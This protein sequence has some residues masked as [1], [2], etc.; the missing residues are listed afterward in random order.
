MII[1]SIYVSY[2]ID[3]NDFEGEYFVDNSEV[4]LSK[5][6]LKKILH[7]PL[8]PYVASMNGIMTH[9]VQGLVLAAIFFVISIQQT[10]NIMLICNLIICF[11]IVVAMWHNSITI[12]QYH[13]MRTN[14]FDTIFPIIT[15][16]FQTILALAIS[17]PIY[18]F[19]AL[20]TVIF[21]FIELMY[22]DH[23]REDK[24]PQAKEIFKQHFKDLGPQFGIDV[25]D[26]FMNFL[27][28]GIKKVFMGIVI[29]SILTLFNYLFPI[30]LDW[31]TYISTVIILILLIASSYED[32][33]HFF[34]NSEKL[35]KYGL[36][37]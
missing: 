23:K 6:D 26:E 24:H 33:N 35:K 19:T 4:D 36:K 14:V 15:A 12:N 16:V 25:Y 22:L 20:V 27:K 3:F 34:N 10:W 9:L 7:E 1:I 32:L 8:A 37:W 29:L 30:G 21:I 5:Y 31:K 18:I 2:T 13:V 28:D 11:A 17:Q